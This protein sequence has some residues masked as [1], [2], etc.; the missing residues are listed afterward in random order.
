MVAVIV[1]LLPWAA[2]NVKRRVRRVMPGGVLT[3]VIW[4]I[5]SAPFALCIADFS[6]Y[7]KTYS[8]FATP[9]VALIWLWFTNIAI[10][11]GLE[12]NGE[13]ERGH[14]PGDEP[15]AEPRDTRKL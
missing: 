6:S 8:A 15:Y 10:L 2:P 1:M 14:A 13:L 7:N 11:L 5:A 9:V 3:V 4:L 12:F